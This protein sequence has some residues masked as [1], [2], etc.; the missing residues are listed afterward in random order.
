MSHSISLPVVFWPLTAWRESSLSCHRI[1]SC[2]RRRPLEFGSG[3]WMTC[4]VRT[5]GL[6]A[7]ALSFA[8]ISSRSQVKCPHKKPTSFWWSTSRRTCRCN[9]WCSR[10]KLMTNGCSTPITSVSCLIKSTILWVSQTN[11]PSHEMD[12]NASWT[13]QASGLIQR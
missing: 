10:S 3:M 12:Q 6:S 11:P 5:C 9:F 7:L 13:S 4:A 1:P 8:E 2:K